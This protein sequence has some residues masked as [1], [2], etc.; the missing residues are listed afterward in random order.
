MAFRLLVTGAS[1]FVAGGVVTLAPEDWEVHAVSRSAAPVDRR[2]LYWHSVDPLDE[3]A[4]ERA[5]D[6]AQPQAVIHTAAMADIDACEARQDLAREVNVNLTRRIAD[7][8]RQSDSRLVFVSTDNA[9]D[10]NRGLYAESEPPNPVNF[11]GKTKVEAETVVRD[12][13]PN[14]IVARTALVMGLP[15]HGTGN[16]FIQ[17]MMRSWKEGK[18]VGVP[19][20]EIRTP[21][22]VITLGRALLE[23]AQSDLQGYLHLAGNEV[24]NR[25]A[26]ARRIAERLGYP[27]DLVEPNDPTGIPGRAPRPR[28]VS[29]SNSR[30][31]DLLT[32][33]MHGLTKSLDLILAARK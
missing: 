8:C 11:Y 29:L 24:I 22:D 32:T 23:L 7:L 18:T 5:F 25:F 30:A 26:M 2:G 3:P 31:A 27:P 13:A 15:M 12:S 19:E 33:S 20:E 21:I 6:E 9:F 1:G 10:G 17:R 4:F 16:S 28:D 14:S